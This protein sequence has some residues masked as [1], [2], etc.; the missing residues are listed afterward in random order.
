MLN[1][2]IFI[3]A[4]LLLSR[5]PVALAEDMRF[6]DADGFTG[7]Y[8]DAGTI[9]IAPLAENLPE[10]TD[11]EDISDARVAVVKANQNKRYLYQI[12][13]NRRQETY[14]ILSSEV[15][16]Y[17]TREV[18]EKSGLGRMPRHYGISSPLHSIVAYIYEWQ[19]EQI[20]ASQKSY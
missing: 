4:L 12:R 17:D 15:Q 11:P 9:V 7:Y 6:V 13:F 20:K 5:C 1:K 10:G 18:L 16:A 3:L 14:E 8:V 19:A 2:F